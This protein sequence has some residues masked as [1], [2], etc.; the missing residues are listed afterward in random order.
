[1]KQFNRPFFALLLALLLLGSQQAAFAHLLSHLNG[2]STQALKVYQDNDGK[3]DQ[4][5]D[6]CITCIA[7]AGIGGG[8]P[9]TSSSVSVAAFTAD[10]YFLPRAASVFTRSVNTRRARAPPLFL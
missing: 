10:D 6:T 4:L 7:F 9:A 3:I 8:A 5:A 2:A 1:M